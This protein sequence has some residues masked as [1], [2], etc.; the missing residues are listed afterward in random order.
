MECPRCRI[1]IAPTASFCLERA[2]PLAHT[3]S[4]YGTR[5][6]SPLTVALQA[7]TVLFADLKGSME[8]LSVPSRTS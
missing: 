5:F 2:S 6:C 1:E 3:C 4:R 8:P 7:A